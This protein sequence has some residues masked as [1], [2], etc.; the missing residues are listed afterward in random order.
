MSQKESNYSIVIH[1]DSYGGNFA[2]ELRGYVTG[3]E[4]GYDRTWFHHVIREKFAGTADCD[5]EELDEDENPYAGLWKRVRGE[6]GRRIEELAV[7]PD[8][9][10]SIKGSLNSVR[11]HCKKKPTQKQLELIK[12]WALKFSE[13]SKN[14]WLFVKPI[15]ILGFT[16][17]CDEVRTVHT[18]EQF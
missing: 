6:Y 7:T 18:E 8:S 15:K 2:Q 14:H 13:Y 1:T 4:S 17:E 3:C 16:L 10:C 11:L 9:F 5:W 12:E